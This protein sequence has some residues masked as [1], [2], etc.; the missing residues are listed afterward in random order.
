VSRNQIG[1]QRRA[2]QQ[3]RGIPITVFCAKNRETVVCHFVEDLGC[4]AGRIVC[5]ECA[6]SGWW[7]YME[8]EIPGYACND[9]KGSGYA[10]VSIA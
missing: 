10:L 3:R 4:G 1:P 7:D 8:P 5:L 9:C 6:G 2:L